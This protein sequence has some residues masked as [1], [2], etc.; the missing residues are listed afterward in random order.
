MNVFDALYKRKSIR[1]FLNKPVE[2]EK[3]DRMLDAARFA[4]SGTNTQP[5]HVAV[6]SGDKKT[7]LCDEIESAFRRGEK[8]HP[9]YRY[10]PYE[11]YTPFKERRKACGL[12]LFSAVNIKREDKEKRLEQWAANYRAFDAPVALF[13]YM[14]GKLEKGSYIDIGM[15]IQSVMLMAVEEDLATCPQAALAEYPEIVKKLLEIPEDNVLICGMALGYQDP[16][17]PINS[18]RTPREAVENFTRYYR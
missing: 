4:P 11:W 13:F 12:Q 15:F 9:D 10:Y 14:D 6:V 1:G 17:A 7:R 8:A 16:D 18:Y 2:E 5:W 3:I